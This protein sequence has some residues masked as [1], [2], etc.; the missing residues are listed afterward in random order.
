MKIDNRT[1]CFKIEN[2]PTNLSRSGTLFQHFKSYGTI[3]KVWIEGNVGFV[4]FF[5]RGEAEYAFKNAIYT[6]FG[7][8]LTFQWH[9]PN[10]N[11]ENKE[12]NELEINQNDSNQTQEASNKETF[13]PINNENNTDNQEI[14]I[15]NRD[16][17]RDETNL[18][19]EN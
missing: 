4:K 5:T 8:V 16:S 17:S 19:E 14:Q 10:N 2:L 7:D 6:I 13:S 9:E 15:K 1:S 18:N 11:P 3:E 12:I